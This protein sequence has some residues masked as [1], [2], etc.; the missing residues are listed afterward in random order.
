MIVGWLATPVG[1]IAVTAT[2]S[3]SLVPNAAASSRPAPTGRRLVVHTPSRPRVWINHHRTG[4]S[5]PTATVNV[6]AVVPALSAGA[7]VTAGGAGTSAP[8]HG[9]AGT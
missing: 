6:A 7:Y 5:S 3:G 1:L 8:S 2:S 9:N 4:V